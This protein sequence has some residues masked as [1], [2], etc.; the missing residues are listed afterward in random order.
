M[1]RKK[2]LVIDDEEFIRDVVKDFL[3]MEDIH[4][5]GAE[6]SEQGLEL[7]TRNNYNLILLDRN[8]GEGKAE[9]VIE[10]IRKINRDIPIIIL[11]GDTECDEAHLK[12]IGA[13]EVVFKPFQ[14]DEFVEKVNRFL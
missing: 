7:M 4:T 5:E 6:T 3:E 9:R 12:Q 8:L 2:I 14:M 1:S 11:T 10:Q 13:V